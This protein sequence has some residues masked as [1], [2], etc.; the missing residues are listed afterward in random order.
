MSIKGAM[1]LIMDAK[2]HPE[3]RREI[4]GISPS[5][6]INYLKSKGYFFD[7]GEFEDSVN[8]MHVKCQTQEEADELMHVA[9]WFRL[10]T[11]MTN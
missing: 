10:I 11:T 4:Y 9:M 7:Y 8:M 3:L 2:T 5:N 6:V 1:K